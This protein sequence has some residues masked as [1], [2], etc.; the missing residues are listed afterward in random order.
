[1]QSQ[2]NLATAK[3]K[4]SSESEKL[5]RQKLTD[6][7][8]VLKTRGEGDCAFHAIL[9]QWNGKEVFCEK[10]ENKRIIVRQNLQHY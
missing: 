8:R 9:G 10:M 6:N 7:Y 5:S 4:I 1:M 3:K 2:Y